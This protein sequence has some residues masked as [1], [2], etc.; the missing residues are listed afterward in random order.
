MDMDFTRRSFAFLAI[1]AALL[2]SGARADAFAHPLLLEEPERLRARLGEDRVI[3][4]LRPFEAY[5]AGHIPGARHLAAN[6]VAATGGPVKGALRATDDIEA[7]LG[8]LG[9][10]ARRPVVFYDDRGGFHAAR[11]LWLLEYLGHRNAAVL[12]G[13]WTAWRAAGGAIGTGTAP[14]AS[15]R[16]VS[17]LSPRRLATADYV[18]GVA[19]DPD[20]VVIDVRPGKLFAKGHIPWAINI[21]WSANLRDDK[22]FKTAQD[23][24]AH[25]EAEGITPERNIVLHC[26]T[27]LASAHSYLA[28][29]LMGYPRVR[30][31]HRS[32]A[33]WGSDSA[34][35]KAVG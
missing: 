16:F 24:R 20:T 27:G 8:A 19:N 22:R 5:Q 18:L 23:L 7:I 2:P 4:D 33:E 29:R 6:A 28:L 30:V 21:P 17:A 9:I 11:T 13:G 14:A 12:N 35:P 26:Q 1:G 32:W 3:V 31:Y 34:L 15:S 25:F 10:S